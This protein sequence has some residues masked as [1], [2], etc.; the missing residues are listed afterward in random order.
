MEA[1]GYKMMNLNQGKH[2]TP[3]SRSL[4]APYMSHFKAGLKD[5]VDFSNYED[6]END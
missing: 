1:K 3:I 6:Q 2:K 5:R 4:I